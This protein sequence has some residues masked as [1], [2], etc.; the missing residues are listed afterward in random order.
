MTNCTESPATFISDM[1]WSEWYWLRKGY[2][3]RDLEPVPGLANQYSHSDMYVYPFAA[4]I[5]IY[6]LRE[7][8]L[9]PWILKPIA[10]FHGI[11]ST[12]GK[13][14]KPNPA[15]ER[16]YRVNRA[17]PPAAML[18]DA[19]A[20]V[21]WSERRVERWL[22]QRTAAEQVSTQE[23]FFDMAYQFI[24]YTY[25]VVNMTYYLSQ[26]PTFL[27][28]MLS[29]TQYPNDTMPL[30]LR[31]GYYACMG[32]YINQLFTLVT[33]TRKSDF[34]PMLTHHIAALI[35][36]YICYIGK[37]A[38]IICFSTVL[39]EIVDI[40]LS[41]AKTLG[42]C[43]YYRVPH[44]LFII[45][46]VLWYPTRL[47]MFPYYIMRTSFVVPPSMAPVDLTAN[48]CGVA[49]YAAHL[50]WSVELA[51]HI[52]RRFTSQELLRDERS[53][54]DEDEEASNKED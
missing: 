30:G 35:I 16:L 22:R 11:K 9:I 5:I 4:A 31:I 13:P 3:W 50:V 20:E 6:I 12:V 27:N 43:G 25:S 46:C 17:R 39:H 26:P 2:S 10:R 21:G 52:V 18:H 37:I 8:F 14:P 53:S 44:A 54:P 49:L 19:A 7:Y 23:K 41:L 45:L 34:I 47:V 1:F 24:Y 28:P 15:L 33:S 38:K 36:L 32:F 42:Y 29:Y 40:P 48:L 51:R